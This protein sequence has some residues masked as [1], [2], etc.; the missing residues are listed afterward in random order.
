MMTDYL[1]KIYSFPRRT[2]SSYKLYLV[3]ASGKY[4]TKFTLFSEP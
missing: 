3:E 2:K 4:L 1:L